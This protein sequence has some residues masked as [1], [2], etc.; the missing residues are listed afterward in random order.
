MLSVGTNVSFGANNIDQLDN[1]TGTVNLGNLSGVIRWILNNGP[2]VDGGLNTT[3]D[4]GSGG[5]MFVKNTCTINLGALSGLSGSTLTGS[6]GGTNQTTLW[7]IGSKNIDSE[8]DGV[9]SGST[10]TQFTSIAKVGS[11]TLTLGG[12]NTYSGTTTVSSGTLKLGISNAIT[13]S[14]QMNLNGGTLNTNGVAQTMTSTVLHMAQTSA[15]DFGAGR[16]ATPPADQVVFSTTTATDTWT[17]GAYLRVSNWTGVAGAAGGGGPDQLFPAGVGGAPIQSQ[18]DHIHFTG[19]LGSAT[20]V[21]SG[22]NA[23]NGEVVPIATT[24]TLTLGDVN[25]DGSVNNTDIY[26]L[27]V[28][29][30][31]IPDYLSGSLLFPGSSTHVRTDFSTT[32]IT[33]DM[34]DVAD[35]NNDNTVNNLDIQAEIDRVVN[36][37][38]PAAIPGSI[39]GGVAAG[40]VAAVPEPA[41]FVLLG[42]ALPALGLAWRRRRKN[43]A[44]A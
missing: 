13:A 29:L 22:P 38:P 3:F 31:D 16:G 35:L 40:G 42:L 2:G 37:P 25:R 18:L 23:A 27:M 34:L 28:A 14:S 11:G 17:T 26:A 21:T 12:S 4:L 1:F 39:P 44:A 10:A 6:S 36:G 7:S 43:Q 24:P 20:L 32:Y 8:F 41:S 15:I 30:T 19:Y 5:N 9:I 33:P